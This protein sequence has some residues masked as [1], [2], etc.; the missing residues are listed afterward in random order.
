MIL[1]YF[2]GNKSSWKNILSPILPT[3]LSCSANVLNY[4][5]YHVYTKSHQLLF[6]SGHFH[7]SATGG[8]IMADVVSRIGF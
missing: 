1:H 8:L 3:V 6:V 2:L 4:C 5:H 7:I